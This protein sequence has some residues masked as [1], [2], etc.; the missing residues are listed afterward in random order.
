MKY[1]NYIS[2][3]VN[4]LLHEDTMIEQAQTVFVCNLILDFTILIASPRY[5]EYV[6]IVFSND[7]SIPKSG[8]APRRNFSFSLAI[9][10]RFFKGTCST[11]RHSCELS[12]SS[13]I[14]K[15][16]VKTGRIVFKSTNGSY[17]AESLMESRRIGLI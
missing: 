3:F 13:L 16:T 5:L 4:F 15:G 2:F 12:T 11:P 10:V 8:V 7:E 9:I 14:I 6:F 17:E 1:L